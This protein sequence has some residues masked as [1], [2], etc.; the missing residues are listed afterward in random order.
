MY[1]IW[2]TIYIIP[3][4]KR[5]YTFEGTYYYTYFFCFYKWNIQILRYKSK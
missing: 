3:T 1:I 2:E 4:I 5:K